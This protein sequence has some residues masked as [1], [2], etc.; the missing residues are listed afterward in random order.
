MY[1]NQNSFI[2]HNKS[3]MGNY[4]F[5]HSLVCKNRVRWIYCIYYQHLGKDYSIAFIKG[6]EGQKIAICDI[7]ISFR[8]KNNARGSY[9]NNFPCSIVMSEI[10]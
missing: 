10:L 6:V 3:Y 1:S 8:G 5:L 9:L 2:L 7:F 4:D